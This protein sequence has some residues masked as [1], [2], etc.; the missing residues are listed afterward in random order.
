MYMPIYTIPVYIHEIFVGN[1][2]H[3]HQVIWYHLLTLQRF[4]YAYFVIK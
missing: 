3:V 4:E 1:C 2:F